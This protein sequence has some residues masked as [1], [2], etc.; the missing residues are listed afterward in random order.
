MFTI[1]DNNLQCN[2]RCFLEA[3]SLSK[4]YPCKC[5]LA[6]VQDI[7]DG[8]SESPSLTSYSAVVVE[9]LSNL[10]LQKSHCSSGDSSPGLSDE[11]PSFFSSG[12]IHSLNSRNNLLSTTSPLRNYTEQVRCNNTVCLVPVCTEHVLSQAVPLLITTIVLNHCMK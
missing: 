3:S 5:C 1:Y 2:V 8:Y 11:A 9:R 10:S 6:V 12:S 7:L 4:V